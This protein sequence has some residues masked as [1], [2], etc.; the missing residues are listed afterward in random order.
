MSDLEK[1]AQLLE[2]G[3]SVNVDIAMQLLRGL[4]NKIDSFALINGCIYPIHNVEYTKNIETID[5][6]NWFG[7]FH[8]EKIVEKWFSFDI[9]F[10]CY[11]QILKEIGIVHED[12]YHR[13]NSINSIGHYQDK[14][15][16]NISINTN[17]KY[18]FTSK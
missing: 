12:I 5:S 6:F 13:D 8:E 15:N 10:T 3:D 1:I 18:T 9:H 14:N 11:P 4:Y 17:I 2:S 7:A 16:V